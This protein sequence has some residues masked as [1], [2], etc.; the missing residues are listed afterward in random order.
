MLRYSRQIPVKYYYSTT[1]FESNSRH[2]PVLCTEAI[3]YLN[4]EPQK[5]YVDMTFGAGGHCKKLLD[6][7][8][9]VAKEYEGR[10]TPLLGRFSDLPCLLREQQVIRHS[11]DG[12]LFDFGC[13][14]MQFDESKRGFSVVENGP[15]DMRM[16]CVHG[17]NNDQVTAADV[18]A[19]VKVEDLVKIL[20]IY[21][22]EKA[23]K[24]IARAIVQVRLA[25]HYIE[26]TKQLDDLVAN[27]LHET[28][29]RLDKLK[30][31]SHVATKTFQALRIFVN[32][33]LNEINYGMILANNYLRLQTR[34]VAITF[35]SLEDIIVKCHLNG[36][37]IDGLAN[38]ISL[39]YFGYDIVHD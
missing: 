15:L 20:R 31:P 10:L 3:N 11:V 37:V 18:L 13:S 21:G 28:P 23:A 9:Q 7:S 24:E 2:I 29:F 22:E 30:C 34:L 8:Q 17:M 1:A 14:S 39:K 25:L 12:V 5:I 35:H 4:P 32:N 26:T 38:P 33:E 6:S 16:D 36:N 19:R 27:C